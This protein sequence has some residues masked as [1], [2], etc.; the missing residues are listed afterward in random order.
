MPHTTNRRQ[1]LKTAG[2]AATATTAFTAAPAIAKEKRIWKMVMTWQK[3]LPGLGTGAVRLAERITRMSEGKLEIRVYGGGELV[4]ALGCF[5]AVVDGTAEMAHCA[6]Y[7]WLSKNRSAAFFCTVPGGLTAQEQNA[8]LYFGD[9]LKL[10]HELYGEYGLIAFPAGNTGTQMG[11]WFKK[12]L[13]NLNDLDGL[14]M[15][16]PGLA[17][18]VFARLGGNPQTIPGSGIFTALQSGVIDAT[19]WVGPWND[20]SLGFNKIAHN[21]YGPAFQEG[22]PTLELMINRKAFMGLPEDLQN[23]IKVACATENMLMLSE[24]QYNNLQSFNA[25]KKDPNVKIAPYPDEILKAFFAT[26]EDVVASTADLGDINRRIYESYSE[27]R[28]SCLDYAPVTEYG[29]MKARY[30]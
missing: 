5:D 3:A 28:K 26:A 13:H 29:F 10:W 12:P 15:R 19:E 4:P 6:P 16:I 24:F 20:T 21:Y 22:G 23:L 9:G 14:K 17:G 8:W 1:F 7:Y 30:K 11:G 2:I 25:L 27:F 18:E